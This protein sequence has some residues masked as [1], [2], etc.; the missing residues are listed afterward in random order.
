M[1][2]LF[3]LARTS[4]VAQLLERDDFAKRYA[5]G[6]PISILELLY[7]LL[8]GYDSVAIR[9]D[10]E[11]GGTDQKLQPASRARD[12]E[13][14]RRG[15][16]VDAHDADPAGHRRRAEDV[17]VARQLRGRGRPAR[18]DVREADAGPGRR[19]ADLLRAAAG[20][21]PAGRPAGRQARTWRAPS[22]RATTARRP[23][24]RRRSASTPCT[25]AT[26]CPTTSRSSPSAADNGAVHLPALLA[27]AFG[28][29]RSEAR[30]LLAQGGVKL[31]GEELDE[32]LDLPADAARRRRAPGRASGASR[33]FESARLAGPE[34]FGRPL[35]V[36]HSSVALLARGG[37]PTPE[38][39]RSLKTQQY[40]RP[41][42]GRVQ[43]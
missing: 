30:R 6:E 33:G 19:D 7:P 31:D 35:A 4:T 42:N 8:Q 2:D 28:L 43:V 20:R 29:S 34:W 32:S 18:G 36:L 15:A 40:V 3:R 21:G 13:G 22:R 37:S 9:A 17:E 12:T 38:G 14:L 11:L 41:D 26:S 5:G 27:E 25:C 24:P 23:P 39:A 10:V 1:E 16:A